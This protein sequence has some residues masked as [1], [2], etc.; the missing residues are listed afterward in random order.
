VKKPL[1]TIREAWSRSKR[2]LPHLPEGPKQSTRKRSTVEAFEPRLLFSAD[3]NALGIALDTSS[4]QAPAEHAHA[5]VVSSNVHESTAVELV[6]FDWRVQDQSILLKDIEQQKANGR[7]I[8]VLHVG[9]N[10]DGIGSVS[11]AI[12][13]FV[14]N[15]IRV[16]AVH[17]VSHGNDGEFQLGNQLINQTTLRANAAQLS[18]WSLGLTDS[19]D[20]LIYGCNF[21]GSEQGRL[22]SESLAA[23]TGADVAGNRQDTGDAALGGDWHL[24]TATGV[25]DSAAI[26]AEYTTTNWHHLLDIQAVNE[27]S[28]VN[29]LASGAQSTGLDINSQNIN[30][31]SSGGR[32]VDTDGSGNYVVVWNDEGRV[33]VRF[34]QSDGTPSTGSLSPPI[35][36]GGGVQSQPAIAM[37][38]LGQSVM[39]WSE[40]STSTSSVYVQRYDASSNSPLG[41][42]VLA[43]GLRYAAKPS[44]AINDA[45]QFVIGYESLDLS[46]DVAIIAQGFNWN[47]STLS[48]P[49]EVNSASGDDPLR[50]SVALRGNLAAIA[51]HDTNAPAGRIAV[52]TIDIA[53]GDFSAEWNAVSNTSFINYGAPDI[54]IAPNNNLIVTW[55]AQDSG[56]M[57][58]RFTILKPSGGSF[59]TVLADSPVNT[60][61][62]QDHSLPKIAVA[63]N[64]EFIIAQQSANHTPD[65]SGWGVIARHFDATGNEILSTGEMALAYSDAQFANTI[66][67]QFAPNIAWRNGN[68]VAVWTS[69]QDGSLDV[70]A[71]QLEV[72]TDQIIIVDT[73]SD[74]IDGDTN[75]FSDFQAFKGADD[76]TSLAEAILVAN[77]SP[78]INGK[79]DRIIFNIPLTGGGHDIVLNNS[80]PPILAPVEIDGNSQVTFDGGQVRI[81]SSLLG[82]FAVL[83]LFGAPSQPM[84]SGSNILGI[85]IQTETG[86]GIAVHSSNNVIAGNNITSTNG[87]GIILSGTYSQNTANNNVSFNE[88]YDNGQFGIDIYSSSG[89]VIVG[90]TLTTNQSGGIRLISPSPSNSSYGN[91]VRDN[92][93]GLSPI[94]IILTGDGTSNNLIIDNKIGLTRTLTPLAN[95]DAGIL[96]STGASNNQIGDT[97]N[98]EGNKIAYT[99]AGGGVVVDR[100][101]PIAASNNSILSN[102]IYN[103]AGLGILTS[104]SSTVAAPQIQTAT[105]DGS[106]IRILGTF[107]GVPNTHYRIEYFKNSPNNSANF[108]QG[109]TLI[110]ALFVITNGAGYAS[111]NTVF[112]GAIQAGFTLT[113]TATLTN[114]SHTTY[115]ATSNFSTPLSVGRYI[116]TPE[117]L[118]GNFDV[119][120]FT[121]NASLPNL[122]YSL[123]SS[124]DFE[125]FNITPSGVLSF[126]E[127]PN[128]ET[129]PADPNGGADFTRWA[130]VRVSNGMGYIDTVVHIFA[131]SDA[132]DLPVVLTGAPQTVT[133]GSL[134]TFTGTSAIQV[135]DPDLG[136]GAENTVMQLTVTAEI[137]GGAGEKSGFVSVGGAEATGTVIVTG[138]LTELNSHLAAMTVQ[139]SP[140]ETRPLRI[141]VTIDDNGSGFVTG[142][143]LQ[144]TGSQAISIIATN[145]VPSI[146][147]VPT[148]VVYAEN[149]AAQPIFGTASLS[150]PDGPNLTG[151]V[152]TYSRSFGTLESLN[153]PSTAALGSLSANHDVASKTY[154]ITG[155]A[156][157]AVYEALLSSITFENSAQMPGTDLIFSLHISDGVAS[158]GALTTLKQVAVNDAPTISFGLNTGFPT[159]FGTPFVFSQ[160]LTQALYMNDP[161][162]VAGSAPFILSITIPS[163]AQSGILMFDAAQMQLV[164]NS[165]LSVIYS[166]ATPGQILL[167]GNLGQITQAVA[168]LSYK[169]DPL[170]S[171]PEVISFTLDDRGNIGPG[172]ALSSTASVT[173]ET[174]PNTAPV[175]SGLTGN[176]IY[177]ENSG[178]IRPFANLQIGDAEQNSLSSASVNLASGFDFSQDIRP[179]FVNLPGGIQGVWSGN[180][181]NLSGNFPIST[182]V[183]ALQSITFGNTSDTPSNTPRVF[184]ITVSDGLAARVA[185]EWVT[186]Q[187]TDDLPTF[188]LPKNLFVPFGQSITLNNLNGDLFLT[189]LDAGSE[190]FE[191]TLSVNDG[192][193]S[194]SSTAGI[195]VPGGNSAGDVEIKI[196]G[197]I[198]ALNTAL[199]NYVQFAGSPGFSNATL[200]AALEAVN[201]ISN[202]TIPG[203]IAQDSSQ[204]IGLTG[205][206]I[207]IFDG[208]SKATYAENDNPVVLNPGI[209]FSGGNTGRIDFID[210]QII[211]DYENGTDVLNATKLSGGLSAQW[212]AVLGHLRISG[213][214]SMA[215]FVLALQSVTFVSLSENPSIAPREVAVT[216]YDGL[217]LSAAH[218]TSVVIE[219][220]ND[221]PQVLAPTTFNM[222]EDAPATPL[223][224]VKILISDVDSEQLVLNLTISTGTMVWIGTAAPPSGVQVIGSQSVSLSGTSTEINDWAKQFQFQ[225]PTNFNGVSELIWSITDDQGAT[226][227]RT[228]SLNIAPVNDAPIWQGNQPLGLSQGATIALPTSHSNATDV[229]HSPGQLSYV[230]TSLPVGGSL[231]FNGAT[232]NLASTFTQDDVDRGA[233]SY[234][235]SNS[236]VTADA[237]SFVV[238]DQAGAQ[239]NTQSVNFAINAAPVV[240]VST[241]GGSSGSGSGGSGT[242]TTPV[243]TPPPTTTA[244]DVKSVSGSDTVAGTST[245]P[246][247]P[248]VTNASSAPKPA[249]K[250]GAGAAGIGNNGGSDSG[251][252]SGI[253]ANQSLVSG[254]GG[255]A[256]SVA[257]TKNA[258]TSAPVNTKADIVRSD[259]A[260]GLSQF[261]NR[262][263][264]ENIEYAAIIRASLNNQAFTDDV[265]KARNEADRS[266]RL[267]KN[268]VASTTAVTTTLSIGYVI[269]L[270]RGGA[271]LSSLLA[272]LPAWRAVDPLPILG[273][274]AENEEDKD[275]DSLDAMIDKAKASRE[276]KEAATP[277]AMPEMLPASA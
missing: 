104:P 13:E 35:I 179:I 235:H 267:D 180:V 141:F 2:G 27:P 131:F 99:N 113:S 142:P 229:D 45:G 190:I 153:L 5:T 149:S 88:I 42:P 47:F 276:L 15:D 54:A 166:A 33:K 244:V 132:N 140:A 168:L 116:V 126:S 43:S 165:G 8:E 107:D 91:T 94:G 184:Q 102:A 245:P 271:L 264:S 242:G 243:V 154:T 134:I 167:Q 164:Q 193:L 162:V 158:V 64:G 111:V 81:I 9:S 79:R 92:S 204:I 222:L 250:S 160:G 183:S 69:A 253:N 228:S 217:Q 270:V 274:M 24:D 29:S 199:Q 238:K 213:V 173:I 240:I 197:S 122:T 146:S 129:L 56:V 136:V 262:S 39:V 53:T 178:E 97:L 4:D 130:A 226:T 147:N 157:V 272:A 227:N 182:Y 7:Q 159:P 211:Q 108:A 155:P 25:I 212:N 241:G 259:S 100:S 189:D 67:D 219:L 202:L 174:T 11:S 128:Y 75:S 207:E 124:S 186:I 38:A 232:M 74:V 201:P 31:D 20:L 105:T 152:L 50:P 177:V 112:S 78:N 220:Q 269:W 200:S 139:T 133:Q 66:M 261:G 123:E 188:S 268:V 171:G 19:A 263:Q 32:K 61:A 234:K 135:D 251:V 145:I 57:N 6:V 34:F 216:I 118:N 93:I 214:A 176:Q 218:M 46:G 148:F 221:A 236:A 41:G 273:T 37:N 223:E 224:N 120:G 125:K 161:D 239:T 249:S 206:P 49:L 203:A 248:S 144:A 18:A 86:D 260:L 106:T 265:Q 138:T 209:Q 127:N 150:N 72:V 151:L 89:N 73:V 14:R 208:A 163:Q 17:I 62:A 210:V 246:S 103:N 121:R 230:L 84:S 185:N 169:Q 275:D 247:P 137:D 80:L 115:G 225:A 28:R 255:D 71:R 90:N 109:E 55:Q 198:S 117:N 205:I 277:K 85:A 231:L 36:S 143:R 170:H 16:S 175:I 22:F 58:T 156:S 65:S 10:D 95:F 26:A 48:V 51:W 21:V 60:D 252:T 119:S 70:F 258:A 215:E 77:N 101:G 68:I 266:I 172:N 110:G 76:K 12:A 3:L 63:D 187:A 44:V 191:L 87:N 1:S 96:I 82:Q 52:R 194:L 98:N 40:T 114:S 59:I 257:P 83:H 254:R 192:L 196:R 237:F 23:I 30:E 195:T 256:F 181:L 233:I